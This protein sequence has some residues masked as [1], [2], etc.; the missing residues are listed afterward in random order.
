MNGKQVFQ[1]IS[2]A[3]IDRPADDWKDHSGIVFAIL[4]RDLR[5]FQIGKIS[6]VNPEI[7]KN[8]I[9]HN[10]GIFNQLKTN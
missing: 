5:A 4:G 8:V 2:S 1:A 7:G 3:K 6:V 9:V 10:Y